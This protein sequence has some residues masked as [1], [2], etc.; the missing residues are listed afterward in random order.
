MEYKRQFLNESRITDDKKAMLTF[1]NNNSNLIS[2]F[3]VRDL[4]YKVIEK[5]LQE[6]TGLYFYRSYGYFITETFSDFKANEDLPYDQI[7]SEFRKFEI[8]TGLSKDDVSIKNHFKFMK[9][10]FR[11]KGNGLLHRFGMYPSFK[12]LVYLLIYVVKGE[13]GKD[14][15]EAI[16]IVDKYPEFK[17]WEFPTGKFRIPEFKGLEIVS[18]K[19]GKMQIKGLSTEQENKIQHVFDII[20]QR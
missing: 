20:N 13:I 15:S 3:D 7:L 10:G 14:Y 9:N 5:K 17:T 18:F 2:G 12:D 4:Y 16:K 19:N 1:I 6:E 8:S 11:Y